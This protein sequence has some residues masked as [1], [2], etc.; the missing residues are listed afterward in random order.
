MNIQGRILNLR[1]SDKFNYYVIG[2]IGIF[3]GVKTCDLI[4]Y[5]EN[6]LL[7]VREEM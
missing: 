7:K 5:D 4:F 6:K 2:M 3:L 1:K